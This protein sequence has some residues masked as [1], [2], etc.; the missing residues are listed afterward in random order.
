MKATKYFEN[1]MEVVRRNYD[2]ALKYYPN[3]DCSFSNFNTF[4]IC[5]FE[6]KENFND[7]RLDINALD[8]FECYRG[9]KLFYVLDK[10]LEEQLTEILEIYFKTISD[11]IKK[12][13]PDFDF[14]CEYKRDTFDRLHDNVIPFESDY[15][16]LYEWVFDGIEDNINFILEDLEKNSDED[17]MIDCYNTQR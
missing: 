2:I 17:Y 13:Y 9:T 1:R 11:R 7:L 14:S 6:G 15:D 8:N 4:F 16:N 12:Q 3:F 10:A 5:C